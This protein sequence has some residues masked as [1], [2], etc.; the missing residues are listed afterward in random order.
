MEHKKSLSEAA[1]KSRLADAN[2]L[3]AGEADLVE[4]VVE[5]FHSESTLVTV[6]TVEDF[7][8]A[9]PLVKPTQKPTADSALPQKKLVPKAKKSGQKKPTHRRPLKMLVCYF[10]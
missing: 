8:F 4:P 5:H 3:D 2:E 10:R 7:E 6:T 1:E 9:E